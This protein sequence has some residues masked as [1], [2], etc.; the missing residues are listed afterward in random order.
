VLDTAMFEYGD[1]DGLGADV[2]HA[3]LDL[4]DCMLALYPIPADEQMSRD[5]WGGV[6]DRPRCIALALSV[7]DQTIAVRAL[8]AEGVTVHH[9]AGDGRVVLD[10]SALPFPVVLTEQL[11]PGDPRTVT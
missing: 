11:L 5:I 6:H 2:P 8:A 7:A 10:P 3:A 9:R 1:G 4:G